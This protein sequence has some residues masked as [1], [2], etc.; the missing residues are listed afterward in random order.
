M[1]GIT[2]GSVGDIVAVGEIAWNIAKALRSTRGSAQEYQKLVKE[3]EF[4][5]KALL[6]VGVYWSY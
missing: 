5:N 1:S 4:F 6:Q 3:L 2:F